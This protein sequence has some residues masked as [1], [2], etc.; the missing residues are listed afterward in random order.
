MKGY[1]NFSGILGHEFVGVVKEVNGDNSDLVGK[2]VVGDINCSCGSC[3]YCLSNLKNHCPSRNVLGIL[4]KNGCFADYITL[5]VKNLVEISDN[6]TDEQ[7]VMVEPLAAAFEIIEQVY[8]KPTDKVLIL[9]DGKLGLLIGLALKICPAKVLLAGKHE[10]KLAIA[11]NQG[12][13]TVLL[14]DLE[15]KKDYDV[16]IEATGSIS[17]FELAQKL[18]KPRGAIVLKST[19]AQNSSLNLAPVVID[20]VAIIGSRCGHFKPTVK[21]LEKKLIDVEPLISR[22]YKFEQAKEAFEFS[23]NKGVLKILLDFRD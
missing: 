7:A 6:I 19:I 22:I 3:E 5:P 1:M 14:S 11:K 8:F 21:A 2:R 16:V 23:Q 18:V 9:G 12:V 13:E 17:G 20:E 4:N 10:E 15:V